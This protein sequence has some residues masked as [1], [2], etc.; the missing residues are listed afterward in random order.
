MKALRENWIAKEAEPFSEREHQCIVLAG[1]FHDVG[2]GIYSH[3]FDRQV[4]PR[5]FERLSAD[6]LSQLLE[7]V[8]WEH[9]DASQMLIQHLYEENEDLITT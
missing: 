5:I 2:H 3:L 4:M 1:L 6:P 8:K 9:E 7:P